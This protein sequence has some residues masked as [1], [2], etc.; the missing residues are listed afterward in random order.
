MCLY[1]V[2]L[3]VCVCCV[4]LCCF[5][6]L[7]VLSSMFSVPVSLFVQIVVRLF[8]FVVCLCLRVFTLLLVCVCVFVFRVVCVISVRCVFPCVFICCSLS[9]CL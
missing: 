1:R 4:V 9:V 6:V 7:I 3:Y 5:R 8:V 2:C